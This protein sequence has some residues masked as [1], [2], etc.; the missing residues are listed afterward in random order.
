MELRTQ[1][2]KWSTIEEAIY[3]QKSRVQWLKLGDSNTS[4]FYARM[5]SRKSQ[6]QI[7]MLTKEDGTIIRDLEEITREAVRFI[8]TC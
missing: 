4:Y 1:L 8:R 6:N 5:K 7:T 3:K 2:N